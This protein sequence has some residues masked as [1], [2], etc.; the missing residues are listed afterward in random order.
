MAYFDYVREQVFVKAKMERSDFLAL[1]GVY[2]EVAEGYIPICARNRK[3]MKQDC[4][5]QARQDWAK[6]VFQRKFRYVDL[7]V[8]SPGIPR[9]ITEVTFCDGKKETVKHE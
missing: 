1:D 4:R 8:A 2:D 3:T 9:T 5:L 7:K 6:A